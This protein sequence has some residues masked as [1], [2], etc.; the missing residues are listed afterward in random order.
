MQHV[1]EKLRINP[2]QEREEKEGEEEGEEEERDP[3]KKEGRWS[4]SL[5]FIL[6][7]PI[8]FLNTPFKPPISGSFAA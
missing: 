4:F 7:I 5:Y 6:V 3:P 2:E 1:H 8:L